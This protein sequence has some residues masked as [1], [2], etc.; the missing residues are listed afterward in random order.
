[1]ESLWRRRQAR[2]GRKATG[3]VLVVGQVRHEKVG[4][5]IMG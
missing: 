1:M 2:R 4:F 3:K 5:Q